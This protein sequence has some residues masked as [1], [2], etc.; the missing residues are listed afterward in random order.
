MT[1]VEAMNGKPSNFLDF[2]MLDE[3]TKK[4]LMTMGLLPGTQITVLR[5]APMGD[6]LQVEV[7]GVSLAIRKSIAE[8]LNVESA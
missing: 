4:R 6:P 2:G 1:L 7:R 3:M 5:R 8:Q